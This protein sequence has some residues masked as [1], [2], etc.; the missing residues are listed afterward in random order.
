[1]RFGF[2]DRTLRSGK[3]ANHVAKARQVPI[4]WVKS[5][6][7]PQIKL[8]ALRHLFDMMTLVAP[9]RLI[10]RFY[11]KRPRTKWERWGRRHVTQLSGGIKL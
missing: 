5:S 2:C 1:M 11:G 3:V 7:I 9:R 6:T 4:H 8:G 10:W